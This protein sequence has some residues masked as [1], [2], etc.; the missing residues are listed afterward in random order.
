MLTLANALTVS[1]LLVLIGAFGMLR[2]RSLILVLLS[3]EIVLNGANIALIAFNYFLWNGTEFGHYL[4]M[5]S[6]GVAAVE[7][8]IGLAMVI[9]IFRN[10][11]DVTRDRIALLGE[12]EAGPEAQA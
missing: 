1:L 10:H 11:R 9:V 3:V 7:A 4:Y 12:R 5:L 2:R 6:I 8:A